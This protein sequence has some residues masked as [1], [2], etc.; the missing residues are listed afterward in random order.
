MLP[1]PPALASAAGLPRLALP[2][3]LKGLAVLAYA[4]LVFWACVQREPRWWS[5]L[6]MLAPLVVWAGMVLGA[7]LGGRRWQAVL[8]GGLLLALT[9]LLAWLVPAGH[10][11]LVQPQQVRLYYFLQETLLLGLVFWAFAHTLRAGR[12]PLCTVMAAMVHPVLSP[13][14]LRYTRA[15][16]WMW[17]IMI[18]LVWLVSAGL[19]VFATPAVW[20]FFSSVLSP[21]LMGVLFVLEVLARRW[22]LPPMDQSG[23]MATLRAMRSVDW[24]AFAANARQKSEVG[25]MEP[26][27]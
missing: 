18:A 2:A 6:P 25:Y 12:T 8:S 23:L 13:A 19:F 26:R 9:G 5:L 24:R 22:L 16:T 17:A 3:M 10:D 14:Q 27:Q 1:T 21:V 4:A 20:A 11:E 15:I 7:R